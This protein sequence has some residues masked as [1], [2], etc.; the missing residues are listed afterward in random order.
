MKKLFIML[1]AIMLLLAGCNKEE[2]M[3]ISEPF[4]HTGL[5]MSYMDTETGQE[6]SVVADDGVVYTIPYPTKIEDIES[7][8][9]E[10]TIKLSGNYYPET[11]VYEGTQFEVVKV[12]LHVE[13]GYNA[14]DLLLQP[15]NTLYRSLLAHVD[16][17]CTITTPAGRSTG[18]T[19]DSAH[20]V[21]QDEDTMYYNIL[22]TENINGEAVKWTST[23]YVDLKTAD[24]YYMYNYM[25]WV[26]TTDGNTSQK[27]PT[28]KQGAYTVDEF[29]SSG[30]NV[31]VKGTC[32][33]GCNAYVAELFDTVLGDVNYIDNVSIGFTGRFDKAT[34]SLK[35]LAFELSPIAELLTNAGDTVDLIECKV[36]LNSVELN[37]TDTVEIP[38]HA[39]ELSTEEVID[40]SLLKLHEFVYNVTADEVTDEFVKLVMNDP[41]SAQP[42]DCDVATILTVANEMLLNY[43][44]S[45]YNTLLQNTERTPEQIYICNQI[46]FYMNGTVQ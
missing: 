26:H 21:E 8:T 27:L 15:Y 16:Y 1:C 6:V 14:D 2:P 42:A 12:P 11:G 22:A 18:Y 36:T 5:F 45:D 39:I 29:T 30:V 38:H 25:D 19:Y 9:N 43:T 31:Y 4:V 33:I 17:S 34:K 24:K 28:M 35:Y 7:V 40:V 10:Y 41:E 20:F 23:E 13:L 3:P 46:E 37:N 44:L 32:S